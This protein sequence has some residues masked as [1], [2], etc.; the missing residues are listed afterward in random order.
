MNKVINPLKQPTKKQSQ[1]SQR[2]LRSKQTAKLKIAIDKIESQLVKDNI[3]L[4]KGGGGSPGNTKL[5]NKNLMK[6][7]EISGDTKQ[8]IINLLH[9]W[10][11]KM[12]I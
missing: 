12:P 10:T 9:L 5:I 1:R 3:K 11:F 8:E 7:G 4:V 6:G 2:S